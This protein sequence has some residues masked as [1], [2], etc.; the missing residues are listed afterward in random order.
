MSE[1]TSSAGAPAGAEPPSPRK[2]RHIG[3]RRARPTSC[4]DSCVATFWTSRCWPQ[5]RPP[6]YP[7]PSAGPLPRGFPATTVSQFPAA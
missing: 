3:P 5:P 2:S 6:D 7:A 1:K 4:C